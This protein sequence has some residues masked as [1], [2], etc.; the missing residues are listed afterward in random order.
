MEA[1]NHRELCSPDQ[2]F[3]RKRAKKSNKQEKGKEGREE[4]NGI[5]TG[6]GRSGG[7]GQG[8]SGGVSK[9]PRVCTDLRPDHIVLIWPLS[10][11]ARYASII[12]V[13]NALIDGLLDLIDRVKCWE[14]RH[15]DMLLSSNQGYRGAYL[16]PRIQN[17]RNLFQLS[18]MLTQHNET[19]CL[20]F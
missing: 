20:M 1:R 12:S 16:C 18:K 7:Q 14:C 4:V 2:A 5:E 11:P 19:K 10:F 17:A 13:I 15:V 6:P 3:A 9:R 8:D